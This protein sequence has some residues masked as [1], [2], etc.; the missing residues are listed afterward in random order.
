MACKCCR[1]AYQG[2][3][4]AE[5]NAHFPGF[6][7]LEKPTVW[8]FPS[9]LVCLDCGFTEFTIPSTQLQKLSDPDFFVQSRKAA[10]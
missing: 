3:F 6:E 7:G 1:S 10:A 8:L 9:L 4:P 5:I 2:T